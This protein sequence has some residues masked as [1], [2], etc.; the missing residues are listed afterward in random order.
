MINDHT[1]RIA[2]PDGHLDKSGETELHVLTEMH[3]NEEKLRA[4]WESH[5]GPDR[6]WDYVAIKGKSWGRFIAEPSDRA[7]RGG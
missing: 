4:W 2:E 5:A 1:A 6:F 7:D 3:D